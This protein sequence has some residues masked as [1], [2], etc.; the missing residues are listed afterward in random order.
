VGGTVYQCIR[1]NDINRKKFYSNVVG[2]FFAKTKK[3][4]FLT[5]I[6][7]ICLRE[8]AFCN[9]SSIHTVFPPAE[10]ADPLWEYIIRSQTH[11]CGNWD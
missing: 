3:G 11:E 10:Q 9:F 7:K 8:A 1:I 6:C 5:K 4:D 2:M